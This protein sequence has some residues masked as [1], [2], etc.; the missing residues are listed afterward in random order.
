MCFR[1]SPVL[2]HQIERRD[3]QLIGRQLDRVGEIGLI[4]HAPQF[5]LR[6]EPDCS[7]GTQAVHLDDF[8]SAVVDT[9]DTKLRIGRFGI[10]LGGKTGCHPLPPRALGDL[11]D[12]VIAPGQMGAHQ[13]LQRR[14]GAKAGDIAASPR[15]IGFEI[16]GDQP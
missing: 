7:T 9:D 2:A 14:G 13:P 6:R 15:D 1:G 8:A 12:A 10:K 5:R 16:S 3:V 4:T 11:I